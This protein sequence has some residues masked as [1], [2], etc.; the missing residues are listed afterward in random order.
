[1][2]ESEA[3]RAL[4]RLR[5]KHKRFAEATNHLL[6]EQHNEIARLRAELERKE[7]PDADQAR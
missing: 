5:M 4:N 3:H 1:M 7:S 6:T 2:T